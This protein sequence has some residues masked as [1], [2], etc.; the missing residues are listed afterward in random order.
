MWI[1][2]AGLYTSGA[3]DAAGR[4][5]NL[6]VLNAAAL[7]LFERGHVPIIGVNLVLPLIDLAGPA[8]FDEIMLPLSLAAAERCDACLRIGG[9]SQGAD[10]EAARFRARSRPVY[11]RLEDVPDASSG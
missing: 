1:M 6:R 10:A 3:A 2:I 8:R 9:P 7:A 4:A 11:F 5:A